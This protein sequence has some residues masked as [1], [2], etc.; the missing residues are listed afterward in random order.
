MKKKISRPVKRV[1]AKKSPPTRALPATPVPSI[2]VIISVVLSILLL[3]FAGALVYYFLRSRPGPA[4]NIPSLS[5]ENTI[6]QT[7]ESVGRLIELP[8]GEVPQIATVSDITKLRDNPFF[9]RARNGDI[10][11]IYEK[12]RKAILYRPNVD[13]I[14]EVSLL[15]VQAL[16]TEAPS[17]S[18]PSATPVTPS[19]TVS[20]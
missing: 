17:I 9:T 10:V 1:M 7:I 2:F 6:T 13:K 11:L 18:S 12:N 14:I 19:A 16:P 4:S 15:S 8:S 20:P 5:D 3:L